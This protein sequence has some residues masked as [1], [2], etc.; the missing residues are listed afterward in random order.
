MIPMFTWND[1]DP[2]DLVKLK[3]NYT[4]GFE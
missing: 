3:D 1:Q 2:L 4:N